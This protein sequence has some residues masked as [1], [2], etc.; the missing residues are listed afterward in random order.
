VSAELGAA[1]IQAGRLPDAIRLLE[2]ALTTPWKVDVALWTGWLGEAYLRTGRLDEAE[3]NAARA[4]GLAQTHGERGNEAHAEWL[5]AEIA[6][7]CEGRG[8]EAAEHYQRSLALATE[9]GMRPL[10]AQCRAGLATVHQARGADDVAANHH[11]AAAAL[12]GELGMDI[13]R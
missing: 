10:M 2:Q 8:A 6:A 12:R 5:R 1:C 3:R 7:S 11:A 13:G 9:L 4:L